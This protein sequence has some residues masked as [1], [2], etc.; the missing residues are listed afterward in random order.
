MKSVSVQSVSVKITLN[1]WPHITVVTEY[2][3]TLAAATSPLQNEHY[4][5]YQ[6]QGICYD[7][8]L[9]EAS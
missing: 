9:Y 8:W 5:H 1:P 3:E 7:V 4:H 2:G 6:R